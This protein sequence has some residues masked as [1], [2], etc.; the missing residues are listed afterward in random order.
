MNVLAARQKLSRH[1]PVGFIVSSQVN[2]REENVPVLPTKGDTVAS[3][4]LATL[5][6][7]YNKQEKEQPQRCHSRH[8]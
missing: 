7:N 2:I 3:Y 5:H 8:V 4:E 6:A 1:I